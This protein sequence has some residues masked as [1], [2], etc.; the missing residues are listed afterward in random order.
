MKALRSSLVNQL[1]AD[2]IAREQLRQFAGT[3]VSAEKSDIAS[4]VRL[5]TNGKT[6]VYQ[7]VIVAK[8]A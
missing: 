1:L 5:K 6:V 3:T 2:P 7:P 4:S 8:A